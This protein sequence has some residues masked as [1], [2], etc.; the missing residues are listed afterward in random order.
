[1]HVVE[2]NPRHS[3]NSMHI[4]LKYL[5]EKGFKASLNTIPEFYQNSKYNVWL[6]FRH[7]LNDARVGY[8]QFYANC[9]HEKDAVMITMMLG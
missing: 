1:M 3:M 5:R 7:V 8:I 9:T 2:I 6:T 4:L